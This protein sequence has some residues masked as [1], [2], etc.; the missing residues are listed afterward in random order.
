MN[1]PKMVE[2]KFKQAAGLISSAGM[3]P[4]AITDT[5]ME[6][7]RFY[8]DEDDVDFINASFDAKKS[9]SF[10]QLKA[11][12]G[13]SD[14]RIRIKTEAL[15]KKG[16]IFNQPN[17]QGV[18]VYKLLP[19]ILVGTFE[20]TFMTKL[21][22]GEDLA[23]LKKIA[24]LYHTLLDEL[25]DN[26]QRGYDALLPIFESQPPIDRT[27]PL[28]TTE[29]GRAIKIVVDTSIKADD[30]VLPA[31]TV[32]EIIAKFDDIAVGY[33]FCRNYNKVLGHDCEINAPSEV[34]FTFGKSARHTV[35]QGF[36]RPLSKEEA[37]GIMKQAEEAGLVHKAF[38][39]GSNI[40]KEENS[41]CNCCK[42]C[43]DTFT[44]WRNGAVPMVNSTNYLSVID[45]GACTG[46]GVCVERCPVDAISLGADGVAVRVENYCIGCGVCARF[47]PAEAIS[48]QEGQRRVYV[49]PPRLRS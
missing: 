36:A 17:T 10:D 16:V 3:V 43:C 48:L 11:K 37:L 34:C 2:Q 12:T 38:H 13:F 8:L 39:N 41:I 30:T 6:I 22:E 21:P 25:R 45:A 9:L 7:I 4:F 32:S 27:V 20:Y 18:I 31:Q 44:L 46:C 28:Q 14:E 40:N 33:C 47:C 19:L 15:A 29:G 1:D 24:K 35:A 5:L 42:D 26:M 23:P 49:P